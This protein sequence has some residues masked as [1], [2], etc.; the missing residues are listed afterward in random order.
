VDSGFDQNQSKLGVH[1]LAVTLHVL[2]HGHS[3]LDEAVKILGEGGREALALQDAEDLGV[4]DGGHLGNAVVITEKHANLGRGEALLGHLGDD[5]V[6]LLGGDLEPRGRGALVGQSG[7]A[8]ALAGS[9]HA[10]HGCRV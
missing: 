8:H 9:V 5:V 3:L 4:G 10:T 7:T 6:H 1:V 2:A